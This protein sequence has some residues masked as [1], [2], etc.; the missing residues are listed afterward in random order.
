MRGIVSTAVVALS[1]FVV[2]SCGAADAKVAAQRPDPA[3]AATWVLASAD[4]IAVPPPPAA[5][6]AEERADDKAVADAV[7]DRSP[8]RMQAARAVARTPAVQPWLE[9][10]LDLVAGR[11]K[12]PPS[13]SRNYALVAVA[14]HDA[15][16]AAYHYKKRYA[17][18]APKVEG[19]IGEREELS[20]PSEHAA[21]A[22]AGSEV[23]ID[24]YDE[25][26]A[27]ALRDEAVT[28]GAARVDAGA[29]RPSDVKAGL[30]LGRAVAKAVLK[31]AHSD[32][33]DRR[34]TGRPPGGA[35]KYYTAPPG[36][37]SRPVQPLAGT[38]KTWVL[39]S[40]RALRP[41]PPPAF[42][43]EGF[44]EQVRL[45]VRAQKELTPSQ[46][47]AALF[48]AGGEGTPLPPGVWIQVVLESL[49]E[50]SL[51]T[52]ET[53]RLL[54]LLTVAMADAGVASWDA[55]YAYWY[56]RPENAIRD[57]GLAPGWKPLLVTPFFPAYVSGHATYSGAAAEVLAYEFPDQKKLWFDRAQ[58][59]ANSRVWGGI[60]WPIDGTEGLKLGHRI[61]QLVV[62]RA[63]KDDEA[64]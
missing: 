16:V 11:A 38:W 26:P 31:R 56:P 42:G 61:G 19:A 2:A 30:D 17:R 18:A 13:A 55:K 24:L 44:K 14:M 6:S 37:A 58:E 53:A 59:A 45:V 52:P 47:R 36:T 60:H 46:K 40:G 29:S 39:P 10:A 21:I 15:T 8:A 64:R 54:A 49:K 9:H 57:S 32:G 35:P 4:S 62:E 41:P 7:A 23:L 50:A 48:W 27:T 1:A 63:R 5:G 22:A 51:S 43:T 25:A 34:W 12:D 33:A 3:S 28:V 20:Y